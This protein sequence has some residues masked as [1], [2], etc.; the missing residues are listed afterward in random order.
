MEKNEL[1]N[2]INIWRG[3]TIMDISNHKKM[4]NT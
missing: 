2:N 4:L 1:Y 3:N